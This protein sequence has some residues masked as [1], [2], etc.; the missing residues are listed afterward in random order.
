MR[1]ISRKALRELEGKHPETV[2]PLSAWHLAIRHSSPKHP[3]EL[4]GIFGSVDFVGDLTVI[5]VGGNKFRLIARIDY[6][7]QI[8]FVKTILTHKK[9]DEGAWRQ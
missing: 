5:K 7:Y 4:R 3:S 8:V 1:L 2:S 9:Y 6:R